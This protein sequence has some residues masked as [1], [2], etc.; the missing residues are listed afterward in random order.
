MLGYNLATYF[1]KYLSKISKYEVILDVLE[2]VEV[3]IFFFFIYVT[4]PTKKN[5]NC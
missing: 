4:D 1:G 5:R 3:V 2:R